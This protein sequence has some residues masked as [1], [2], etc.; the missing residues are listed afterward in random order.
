MRRLAVAAALL[1]A[2]LAQVYH[3]GNNDAL[4]PE[5]V[6]FTF[7][8]DDMRC[9]A[10]YDPLPRPSASDEPVAELSLDLYAD[11]GCDNPDPYPGPSASEPAV[12]VIGSDEPGGE[13]TPVLWL[14]TYL[15]LWGLERVDEA[16]RAEIEADPRRAIRIVI[17]DALQNM[18][19][20][21]QVDG[22]ALPHLEISDV[23]Y[24]PLSPDSDNRTVIVSEIE[25]LRV[26]P[27]RVTAG[28]DGYPFLGEDAYTSRFI[29]T[30]WGGTIWYWRAL[31]N[32]ALVIRARAHGAEAA[33]EYRLEMT[34]DDLESASATGIRA[35][36][37]RLV[38][39]PDRDLAEE[40][41][42]PPPAPAFPEGP[43]PRLDLR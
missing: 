28:F 18:G 33:G 2:A 3:A 7:Q 5:E 22:D 42:G 16:R 9:G 15:D 39:P 41:G 23:H 13:G 6:Y 1:A 21:Y 40:V 17:H 20:R 4:L 14:A 43:P 35:L 30:F 8:E 36:G 34:I 38:A 26:S 12:V 37:G 24:G 31:P 27:D 10:I 19:L 11:W 29:E 32:W 25:W